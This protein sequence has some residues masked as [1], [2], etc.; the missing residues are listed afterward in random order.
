MGVRSPQQEA[1]IKEAGSGSDNILM[2]AC[3]GSGKTT[4]AVWGV[5][6]MDGETKVLATA[7]NVRNADDLRE[8]MP[9]NAHC[10]NFNGLGH[11]AWGKRIRK[12]L[13]LKKW[14]S[15]DIKR[16][17]GM[18]K[19]DHPDLTRLV[20]LAKA[21]GLV[22]TDAPGGMN[23]LIEDTE[24]NW[25]SLIDTHDL[26]VGLT[27]IQAARELLTNSIILAWKGIIDFDDQLY[28]SAIYQGTFEQFDVIVVDE[29]QDVSPIQRH[30]IHNIAGD[31]IVKGVRAR[32]LALGDRHQS[33]YGFR[34][35]DHT[36]MGR[37]EEEFNCK[38]MPLTISFRCPKAIVAE[39]RRF[40]D[41]I[42]P[43]PAAPEGEVIHMKGWGHR[44]FEPGDVILCRNT[45]PLIHLAFTL[46]R[47]GV[48]CVVLGREI[49]EQLQK[50]IDKTGTMDL[51]L[52]VERLLEV[53]FKK[54]DEAKNKAAGGI[55]EDRVDSVIAIAEKVNS[56]VELKHRI[57][58]MF[59]NTRAPIVLSTVHKA[60]GLEW[61]R[62]FFLDRDLIPSRYAKTDYEFE[63]ENNILYVCITRAKEALIYINSENYRK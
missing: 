60:K 32:I 10:K 29:A 3:A 6:E 36:S 54:M 61:D 22:P 45:K 34:G 63:Q 57:Q 8:R 19:E 47:A 25:Q 1:F 62:V 30:M 21:N 53:K 35:A 11:G 13:E 50:L 51:D 49:G 4:T 39:A 15:A 14:K 31:Q 38:T 24:E 20:A 23:G 26:D 46:L 12:K 7:F 18:G 40:V 59:D 48:G 58:K 43:H 41:H 16:S 9:A 37:F 28:M 17:M 52:C 33:I 27:A 44:T 55:W 2:E 42:E 56:V 5:E